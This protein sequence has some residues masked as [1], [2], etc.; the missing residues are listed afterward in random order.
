V[1]LGATRQTKGRH[2]RKRGRYQGKDMYGRV[3]FIISHGHAGGCPQWRKIRKE[4]AESRLR[5]L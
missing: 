2:I 3:Q 4:E 5:G 1:R